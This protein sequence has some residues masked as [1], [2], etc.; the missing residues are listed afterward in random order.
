[1][2]RCVFPFD[3]IDDH[4]YDNLD[5]AQSFALTVGRPCYI[6]GADGN[7]L[8]YTFGDKVWHYIH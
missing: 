1:M 2:I 4:F 5:R 6:F 8:A 3:M 7:K